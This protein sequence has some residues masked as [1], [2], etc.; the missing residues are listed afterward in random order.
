M[1]IRET[2]DLQ[3]RASREHREWVKGLEK[4]ARSKSP[5]KARTAARAQLKFMQQADLLAPSCNPGS[6]KKTELLRMGQHVLTVES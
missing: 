2:N 3:S 4:A 1:K 5:S 6:G